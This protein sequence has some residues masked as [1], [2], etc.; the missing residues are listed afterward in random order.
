MLLRVARHA[1]RGEPMLV[2]AGDRERAGL[3]YGISY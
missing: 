1:L 3:S 2:K